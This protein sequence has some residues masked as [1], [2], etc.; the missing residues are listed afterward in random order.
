MD[1]YIDEARKLLKNFKGDN[2][3]FGIGCLKIL[4]DYVNE[5]GDNTLL[6]I[7]G[8]SWAKVL[9]RRILNILNESGIKILAEVDTAAP[10]TPDE[11]V[12][13]LA[14]IINLTNPKS[15]T[16]VGGGSAI[17]CAKAA[18]VLASLTPGENDLEPFFGVGKVREISKEKEKKPYPL[19]AVQV[20]SGS[21]AHLS[22]N[23]N[24][25]FTR[26]N[27]KKLISD[28]IIVPQRAVFDYYTSLTAPGDLTMDGALDGL[29]HSLEIYF[30]ADGSSTKY[31]EIEK[32]CLTSIVII[33]NTLPLLIDD[34]KNIKYREM[35]GLATDLGGY[36]LM[37]GGTNGPHLN[38]YTLVD[39]V[40]HG[41]ACAILIPYYTVFFSTAIKDKLEKL[42]GIYKRYIDA[43]YTSEKILKLDAR[44]LGEVIAKAM[45]AF[46][47]K[48]GFPTKLDEI[49]RFTDSHIDRAITA[50]K[51][52]QLDT[53]LKNMPVPLSAELVDEYMRPIIMA[54]KVGDFSLIKNIK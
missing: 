29:A 3:T 46:S 22:G 45:I 2:Y 51:N 4:G 27:Q 28:D 9:R 30:G 36:A 54:A 52:P 6:I 39:V 41:R 48:I 8:S 53:K 47:N 1:S 18:N 35:I 42:A 37:L 10:N 26:T 34:L 15:I 44:E 49:E 14:N 20:A 21:G 5:F 25:T 38:S 23:A 16:C 7:S 19:I 40:T 11:D 43:R 33:V 31:S 50:A 24:V 17:D 12:I 13:K 32:V